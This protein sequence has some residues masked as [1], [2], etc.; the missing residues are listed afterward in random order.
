MERG[1]CRRLGG[2]ERAAAWRSERGV[3]AAV[4]QRFI[5]PN[6]IAGARHAHLCFAAP[7]VIVLTRP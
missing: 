5:R 7:G 2:L 3:A 4:G 1:A 6:D